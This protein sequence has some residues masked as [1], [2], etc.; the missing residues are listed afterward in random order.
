[1]PHP[2]PGRPPRHR[3]PVDAGA[4]ADA[5]P[6][7]SEE[8]RVAAL[9]EPPAKEQAAVAPASAELE[10][11]GVPPPQ[12]QQ[13]GAPELPEAGQPESDEAFWPREEAVQQPPH[14][15]EPPTH[16]AL[17]V[18]RT[19]KKPVFSCCSS[20][21]RMKLTDGIERAARSGDVG[22]VGRRLTKRREHPDTVDSSGSTVLMAVMSGVRAWCGESGRE[23][24]VVRLVAGG[25][26]LDLQDSGGYSAPHTAAFNGHL[27]VCRV[28]LGAGASEGLRIRDGSTAFDLAEK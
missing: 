11:Q 25:A 19:R 22:E 6:P 21:G 4:A 27:G 15:E 20:V 3:Q 10:E 1:M 2:G 24:R 7:F 5:E 13:G 16:C 8:A 17:D 14:A 18:L 26:A 28:L 23:E 12:E 9:S